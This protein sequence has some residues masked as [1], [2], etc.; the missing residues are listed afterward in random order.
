MDNS[1]EMAIEETGD[2][3]LINGEIDEESNALFSPNSAENMPSKEDRVFRKAKRS[4][5]KPS[6]SDEGTGNGEPTAAGSPQPPSVRSKSGVLPFSKNSRKSRHNAYRSRGQ[7]KKGDAA[8]LW[9][10]HMLAM[11]GII[12]L[13]YKGSPDK[14]QM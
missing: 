4:A 10:L 3:N 7:P 1:R 14:A 12:K 13:P 6:K 11:I 5:V 2:V 9:V 8:D